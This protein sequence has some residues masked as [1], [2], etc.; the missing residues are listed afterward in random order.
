MKLFSVARRWVLVFVGL[1]LIAGRVLGQGDPP[2]QTDDPGVA[3]LGRAEVTIG[4]EY[5]QT[6][7]ERFIEGPLVLVDYGIAKNVEIT[8]GVPMVTLDKE[9]AEARTGLGDIELAAKWRFLQQENHGVSA[10]F[11]PEV[12]LDNPTSSEQRGLVPTGN[13]YRFTSQVGRRFGK[14][15]VGAEFV[16]LLQGTNPEEWEYGIATG[17]SLTEKLE[18]LG[19]IHGSAESGF[20]DE[21][22]TFTVGTEYEIAKVVALLFSVGRSLRESSSGEPELLSFVGLELLF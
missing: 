2:Q 1:A 8:T 22:L 15:Y 3:P 16:Y 5:E 12:F 6:Q 17:Y 7:D 18:L 21:D 19:E 9:G 20:D 10:A 13:Q 14:L 4:G 11:N